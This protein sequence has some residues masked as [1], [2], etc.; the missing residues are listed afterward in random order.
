[1]EPTLFHSPLTPRRRRAHLGVAAGL[2]IVTSAACHNLVTAGRGASY[3][4][5][6]KIEGASGAQP[7]DFGTSVASDVVTAGCVWTDIGR[8]TMHLALKDAGPTGTPTTPSPN[9]LITFERYHIDFVRTDGRSTPGVD[10]PYAFD[11][12]ATF[13]V[14]DTGVTA[15]FQLVR[16]QAKLEAPLIALRGG[17]G[18]LALSTIAE[19][20]F[21][22]HD[23]TGSAVTAKAAMTVNFADW[24]D[25]EGAK[26]ST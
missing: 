26:C 12:A 15:G 24:G 25:P 9:N 11:G 18:S 7:N 5:V 21:Y 8:V 16:L 1:M 14:P 10:V 2:A 23:Q 3:V 13:T 4:I 17:G 20:T 19:I 6:D 22:G